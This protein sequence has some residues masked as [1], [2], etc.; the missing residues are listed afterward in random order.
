MSGKKNRP[1][2]GRGLDALLGDDITPAKVKETNDIT[3]IP[4]EGDK[5]LHLPLECLEPNPYQP[6][7]I[8]VDED[9][10][11]L[12]ASIAQN[13]VI[14][15]LVARPAEGGYQ[16]IAGERRWRAAQLA[17]LSQVP[18]VV[19]T[20]TDQQAL[21]LALLE[22]LQRADLNA[23]E[24]ARAY[25]RLVDEF[26]FNHEDI[27]KGVGKDRSTISNFL[28]L[29]KLPAPVQEDLL[30]GRL[31]PGHARAL[32]ALEN[33]SM[34]RTARDKIINQTLSVRE[35]ENLVRQM[36]A[37]PRPARPAEGHAAHWRDLAE[38][39]QQDLGT[40]VEIK[41]HGKKGQLVLHFFSYDDLE[42]LLEILHKK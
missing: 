26:H 27:A 16:L 19:R 4:K 25:Q 17:G 38:K 12:A 37:P 22:N 14:E 18:V 35:A 33:E 3:V 21:F 8:F 9:L 7:K 41:R 39:L 2:L 28:R 31:T 32:L 13:G 5:I 11:T 1:A 20:A 29:L 15:P 34:I 24:E 40:K 30:H 6:R 10:R 23:L 42:R 36:L